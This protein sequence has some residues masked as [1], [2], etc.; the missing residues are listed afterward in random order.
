MNDAMKLSTKVHS[1]LSYITTDEELSAYVEEH[2]LA[3]RERCARVALDSEK[4]Y[5]FPTVFDVIARAIRKGEA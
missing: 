3:E 2:V 1:P 5:P 4:L